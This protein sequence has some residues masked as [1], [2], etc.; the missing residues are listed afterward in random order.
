MTNDI[1]PQLDRV[2][3]V[4]FGVSPRVDGFALMLADFTG[5]SHAPGSGVT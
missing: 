5:S 1:T 2:S 3:A 4:A